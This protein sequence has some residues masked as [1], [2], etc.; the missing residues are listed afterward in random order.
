MKPI[1]LANPNVQIKR[2]NGIIIILTPVC[3]ENDNYNLSGVT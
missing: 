3:P 2:I 1:Q